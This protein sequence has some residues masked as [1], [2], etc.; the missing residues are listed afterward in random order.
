MIQTDEH[1]AGQQRERRGPSVPRRVALKPGVEEG[2]R[3][4]RANEE[5]RDVEG[6]DVPAVANPD[7]LD[8][9]RR[10]D[11]RDHVS[12]MQQ[13]RGGEEENGGR[14]VRLVLGASHLELL[15]NGGTAKQNE[16]NRGQREASR[17][18]DDADKRGK[19]R[20]GQHSGEVEPSGARQISHIAL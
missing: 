4:Q 6:L 10:Q 19:R 18:D 11:D 1:H 2:A 13:Q 16:R 15:R 3:G 8:G 17:G 12:G 7:Q 14:V 5:I 9:V 20:R